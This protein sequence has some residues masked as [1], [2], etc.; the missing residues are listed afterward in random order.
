M[1]SQRSLMQ[2][3]G[4]T[5][6]LRSMYVCTA[7]GGA[8]VVSPFVLWLR[9]DSKSAMLV[10]GAGLLIVALG[11]AILYG[12]L[13]C[14]ACGARW[15]LLSLKQPAGQWLHWLRDLTSCPKCGASNPGAP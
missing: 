8:L 3:T 10:N 13:R 9:P 6:K 4:Q 14:P 15:A 7:V 12:T 11:F 1:N 2:R 5:W